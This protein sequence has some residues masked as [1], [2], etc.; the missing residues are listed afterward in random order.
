MCD[1]IQ[2]EGYETVKMGEGFKSRKIGAKKWQYFCQHKKRT[3]RCPYCGGSEF[4]KHKRQRARCIDCNG[5]AICKHKKRKAHCAICGGNEFCKHKRRTTHCADCHFKKMQNDTT[6][7]NKNFCQGCKLTLLGNKRKRSGVIYCAKCEPNAKL[8]RIEHTVRER[9]LELLDFEPSALDDATFGGIACGKDDTKRYRPDILF[10]SQRLV[11][12]I[13]IDENGG[14]PDELPECHLGRMCALTNI[15][16]KPDMFSIESCV[17]FLRFNPDECDTDH[18]LLETRIQALADRI[19][20][21]RCNPPLASPRP[22]V[23][24]MFYHSKCFKHVLYA[25]SNPDAIEVVVN[26]STN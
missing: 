18:V 8:A 26:T 15:F 9:L 13:E 16:Q 21:L 25:M 17:Y 10:G 6:V 20:A 11:I 24:Y 12:D 23:E 19:T 2:K 22:K 4:C 3:A 7:V 5:S 1:L 14:H